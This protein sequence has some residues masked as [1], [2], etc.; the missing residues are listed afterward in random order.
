MEVRILTLFDDEPIA[1]QPAAARKK[2]APKAQKAAIPEED[3]P[4]AREPEPDAIP[5]PEIPKTKIRRSKTEQ[6]PAALSEGK[7]YYT[8]GE[9]AALFDVRISHIR[10]WTVQFALKVRTTRKGDRL[11]TPENITQL[12]LIHQLVKQQ[13]YTIAGAKA[14]LKEVKNMSPEELQRATIK[15][16]L[17]LL[18]EN[19]LSLRK[20]L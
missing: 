20:H 12:R 18:K 11:F 2:R 16:S 5:E 6:K 15:G 9:T 14:R 1:P 8:I 13:G 19:L 10:F 3:I 4:E 7:S 17:L